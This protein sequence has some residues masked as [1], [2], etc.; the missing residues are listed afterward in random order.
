MLKEGILQYACPGLS[1]WAFML[2]NN[3]VPGDVV[4]L[5]IEFYGRVL[6][7]K[8]GLY[9]ST[10]VDAF[11]NKTQSAVTQFEATHAREMFP[12]F[13]EPNFKATF[14]VLYA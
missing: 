3:V 2:E 8:R 13:D 5:R 6:E 12:C 10:H 1:Q 9:I 11:G 14:Q 7:D 4:E